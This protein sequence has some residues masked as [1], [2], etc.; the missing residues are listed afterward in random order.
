MRYR[1]DE[2]LFTRVLPDVTALRPVPGSIYIT[3][4]SPEQRSTHL[5]HWQSNSPDV[6]FMRIAADN[7]SRMTATVDDTTP[8][9]INL[10]STSG[11]RG[12]LDAGGRSAIYLD[13]TGLPHHVWAPLLRTIRSRPEP[14]FVVY[15]EP[16]DYRFSAS[17]TD[18]TLFDLSEKIEGISPLP[19]FVTF[20]SRPGPEALFVPLLGFEGARL[21]FMLEAV[22]PKRE[23]VVPIVGVPG[24]R[25]EYP[26]YTYLGNRS[27]LSETRA[28]HN[29]RFA[30]ANCPFSAY[31]VIGAI[32]ADWPARQ[33]RLGLIG[34]KPHA[35]GAILYFLDHPTET[36][37]L[38]DYPIRKALR[39][40]GISRVC[41]YDLSLLPPLRPDRSS[42]ARDASA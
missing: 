10:R 30:A 8:T 27:Q 39:T 17:P 4:E 5:S 21:A 9:T 32:S 11:L 41:V 28:W 42:M 33:M 40:E 36:E 23:N 18:V 24:F 25:P 6:V 35:L 1:V 34:T 12:L 2:P 31:H 16:G 37:L 38:Y 14:S 19:G 22:Q 13:I 15:V 26:F 7:R 20:S 29:V 3:G